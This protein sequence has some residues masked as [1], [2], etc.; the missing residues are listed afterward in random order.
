MT[1]C[2]DR[3]RWLSSHDGLRQQ[4]LENPCFVSPE[5]NHFKNLLVLETLGAMTEINV[6]S[7]II[8]QFWDCHAGTKLFEFNI[9][10]RKYDDSACVRAVTQKGLNPERPFWMMVRVHTF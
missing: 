6:P 4:K 1:G 5:R 10:G 8:Q 3:S 9:A 2:P 7:A